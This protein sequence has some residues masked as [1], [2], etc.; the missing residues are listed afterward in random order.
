MRKQVIRRLTSAGVLAAGL[1]G[2][3]LIVTTP[4]SQAHTCV[5]MFAK[6]P[7][8]TTV[9][10]TTPPPGPCTYHHVGGEFCHRQVPEAV[11]TTIAEIVVCVR[12]T[13]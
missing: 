10:V 6:W 13:E 3:G 11:G 12:L 1:V 5:G 2:A 4:E 7:S 9:E 8:S